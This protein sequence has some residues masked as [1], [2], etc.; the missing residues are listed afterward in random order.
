MF[1][2]GQRLPE[3]DAAI[4][5]TDND[6][7]LARLSAVQKGYLTDPFITPLV[8]R[9]H[10]QP[11]RPPLINIGT[12]VRSEGLDELVNGWLV[13]SAEEGKQCQI[14]SMGAG[15]DTRFWR[16]TG[17]KKD[18]LA[19]YVEIDFPEVTTRKAMAIRKSKELSTHLGKP[20]EVSLANGG[21]TLHSPIYNLL[22]SDLRKPPAESLAPLLT[23]GNAPMLSPSL[24]TL[25]IFE[26]V[27]AYMS[28]AASNAI[29]KW[30]TESFSA[31]L[32][33]VV[34]EMFALNDPFGRVMVNNLKARNVTLPGAEPY[35]TFE[36]LPTRF[37]QHG[38]DLAGALTLKDIRRDY[39]TPAEHERISELEMLDEI[40]EL[41]LV[42]AHY[43]ISWGLRLPSN[44]S[45]LTARWRVWEIKRKVGEQ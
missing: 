6:A 28:P 18:V 12:Y 14:V 16:I 15:S 37:L 1:P 25:L 3:G 4:R 8:P 5:A 45:E 19:R 32:G 22:A 34:Y 42:L 2:P 44:A 30:Y 27:L 13:L 9:A 43:A 39:V 20:E 17:P 38:W 24:P 33:C 26:C 31:P 11:S 7:A 40:E 36:L 21:T 35:T 10:F 23:T 29:L 41:E